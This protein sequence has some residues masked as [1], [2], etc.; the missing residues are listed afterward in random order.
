MAIKISA[1]YK[2]DEL[3][4]KCYTNGK[5]EL[6]STISRINHH[7][8]EAEFERKFL[9][10]IEDSNFDP[11]NCPANTWILSIFGIKKVSHSL[12]ASVIKFFSL[13][14][15]IPIQREVY[16]RK[17][18]CLYWLKN[19]LDEILYFCSYNNVSCVDTKGEKYMF[20]SYE[21]PKGY[22]PP[23]TFIP[24]L[25]KKGECTSRLYEDLNIK[26]P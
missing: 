22:T 2:N 11:D 9:K 18:S 8:D 23:P 4:C 7:D 26:T 14:L 15:K 6:R 5:P 3:F 19:N 17:K 20:K 25:Y 21:L 24:K 10:E 12:I 13:L 1:Y 16:R